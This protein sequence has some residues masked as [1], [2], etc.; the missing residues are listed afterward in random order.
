MRKKIN[1]SMQFIAEHKEPP[2]A[3]IRELRAIRQYALQLIRSLGGDDDAAA[4]EASASAQAVE[5]ANTVLAGI[6]PALGRDFSEDTRLDEALI[7]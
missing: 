2:D 7:F 1:R 6:D 4:L 3:A 5:E